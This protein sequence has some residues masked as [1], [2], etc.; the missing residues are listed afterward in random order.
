M[1]LPV[2]MAELLT[3]SNNNIVKGMG[4]AGMALVPVE[5]GVEGQFGIME[6]KRD[7]QD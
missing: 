6:Q 5:E 7:H 2:R 1:K 4:K 3:L